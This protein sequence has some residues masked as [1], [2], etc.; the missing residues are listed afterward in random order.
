[1]NKRIY[2]FDNIKFLLIALVVVGHFADCM[3]NNSWTMKSLILFI[4]SFHMPLFIYMAGLFHKN[5]NIKKRCI[6]FIALGIYLKILFYI[7]KTLLFHQPTFSLLSDGGL[8][9]FMFAMAAF[10]AMSYILRDINMSKLFILAVLLS[11]II[12]FDSTIGDYLYLSRIVVFYPFYILGQLTNKSYLLKINQNKLLKFFS[13]LFVFIWLF[14]CFYKIDS[15]YILR[16]LFTG[17]N[18][19]YSQDVF[20]FYGPLY[21]LLCM[22]ISVTMGIALVSLLPN[23]KIP[24]I[25]TGGQRT[26]QIF[27][28]HYPFIYILQKSGIVHLLEMSAIGKSLWLLIS[29]CVTF[30]LSTKYFSYITNW[31]QKF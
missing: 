20:S 8:P 12:G 31:I 15:L 11:C 7:C 2:L 19:F 16:P 1:M 23:N 28:W 3:T 5:M 18:S 14:L 4:Y 9:W 26:L 13:I 24:V 30:I 22:I 17:R 10:T 6:S 29:I 21:R 25:S 27:F